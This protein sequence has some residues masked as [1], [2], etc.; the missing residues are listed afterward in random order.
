MISPKTELHFYFFRHGE[1]EDN[2]NLEFVGGKDPQITG[3]GLK[4]AKALGLRLSKENIKFEKIYCSSLQRVVHTC[5]AVCANILFDFRKVVIVPALEELNQGVLAGSRKNEIYTGASGRLIT[6]L[7][8]WF[9]PSGGESQKMVQRRVSEWFER[10]FLHN[11][12]FL[13]SEKTFN[14]GIF[15]S[16]MNFKCFF[17]DVTGWDTNSNWKHDLDNCS[18][19]R[20]RF[21]EKGWF[22]GCTN[23]TG[24]LLGLI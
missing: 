3:L 10:E 16:G 8:P 13:K 15:G 5:K 17:Q 14:F 4:Q 12:S 23:D 11:E 6:Y 22:V 20:F 2:T 1:S 24:H 21:N 7:G 18:I 9:R 19:S